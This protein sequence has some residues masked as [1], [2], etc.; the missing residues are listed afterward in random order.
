MNCINCS[1]IQTLTSIRS[2]PFSSVDK[3]SALNPGTPW[4]NTFLTMS[5]SEQ[6][7]FPEHQDHGRPYSGTFPTVLIDPSQGTAWVGQP[8]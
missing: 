3:G 7:H 8:D 1:E 6:S 2:P 4:R 5:K